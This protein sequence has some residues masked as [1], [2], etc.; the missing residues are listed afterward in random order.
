MKVLCQQL[1]PAAP[2]HA[3]FKGHKAQCSAAAHNLLNNFFTVSTSSGM[4]LQMERKFLLWKLN[5]AVDF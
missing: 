2:H 4:G 3:V 5:H 1:T